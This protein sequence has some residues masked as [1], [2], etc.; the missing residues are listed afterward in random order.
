MSVGAGI[1]KTAASSRG[2][3]NKAENFHSRST[4]T[5]KHG[6]ASEEAHVVVDESSDNK[7]VH[8]D[9]FKKNYFFFQ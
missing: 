3:L 5:S 6:T 2:M 4:G 7:S 9:R 8:D 1:C